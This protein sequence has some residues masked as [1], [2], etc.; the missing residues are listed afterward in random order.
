MTRRRPVELLGRLVRGL[1]GLA[2]LVV[3]LA[4]I[5]WGLWRYVGWPLPHTLPTWTEL[6]R[7]LT[8]N[9]VPDALVISALAIVVWAAWA[10]LTLSVVAE[11]AAV[12][13]GRTARRRPLAG[14]LQP[15]ASYLVATAMLLLP[16]GS[17]RP[18]PP[19][20]PVAVVRTV[21]QLGIAGQP[22]APDGQPPQP[23]SEERHAVAAHPAATPEPARPSQPARLRYTIHGPDPARASPATPY[24]GSLSGSLATGAATGRST[25]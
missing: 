21:Q 6:G 22:P 2:A 11:T 23:R 10:S 9:G 13:R 25:S 7:A 12:V 5:P 24:G 18:F 15:L 3:L 16:Q 1:G 14:P 19:P 20:Q 17:M 8:S 4:G